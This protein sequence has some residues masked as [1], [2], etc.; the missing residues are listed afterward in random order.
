ML[1]KLIDQKE[2]FEL[3][4]LA[5]SGLEPDELEH[6]HRLRAS[7]SLLADLSFSDFLLYVPLKD[8]QPE[9]G[10]PSRFQIVGQIRP[11]TGQTIFSRD[12]VGRVFEAAEVPQVKECYT[13][14][15]PVNGSMPTEIGK[16]NLSCTPVAKIKDSKHRNVIGVLDKISLQ[17]APRRAGELENAYEFLAKSLI[18]MVAEGTFP[19]Q[20]GEFALEEAPRVGD[21]IMIIGENDLISYASPNAISALHHLGL[22]KNAIGLSLEEVGV[23]I[24]FLRRAILA[25][26]PSISET[27]HTGQTV[28]RFQCIPLLRNNKMIGALILVR[29]ITELKRRERELLSKDATIREVHHRVKNNLQT[30]SSLLRLQARR[31]NSKAGKQALQEAE[32]R[33]RSIAIVHEVLSRDTSEQ[34]PFDEIIELLVRVAKESKDIEIQVKGS[35]GNIPAEIATPLAVVIAELIQN[36]MEHAFDEEWLKLKSVKPQIVIKFSQINDLLQI[37]VSDNGK[38]LYE[39]FSLDNIDSLGLSLVKDLVKTQLGGDLLLSA[40]KRGTEAVIKIS[41]D[42]DVINKPINI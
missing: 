5:D 21:G 13:S 37:K 7:W 33:I 34:V 24:G 26:A 12:L 19:F 35:S 18:D 3:G 1:N 29:D 41:V 22:H 30:I 9:T 20:K 31:L 15:V 39:G 2:A 27:E 40:T 10:L 6:L 8:L 23:D 17:S 42:P 32:R 28:V 25:K 36:A 11:A 14:S 16:V 38:G 4:E